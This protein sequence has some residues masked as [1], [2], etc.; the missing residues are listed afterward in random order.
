MTCVFIFWILSTM[1]FMFE[2]PLYFW[3]GVTIILALCF[4]KKNIFFYIIKSINT[5]KRLFSILVIAYQI[6]IL[7]STAWMIRSDAASVYRAATFLQDMSVTEAYFSRYPNNLLLLIY[8]RLF[9][10]IFGLKYAIWVMQLL[11]MVYLNFSL[12]LLYLIAKK[13]FSNKTADIV[14]FLSVFIIGFSPQ[15]MAM[16]TDI[17]LLP[18]ITIQLYLIAEI[19][20]NRFSLYNV[21]GLAFIS[22]IGIFVRPTAVILIIAA[23]GI[24]LLRKFNR[25]TAIRTIT[26]V[27]I[28]FSLFKVFDYF[29]DQQTIVKLK[30]EDSI[31]ALAYID[32]GLT[33]NGADQIDFQRGLSMFVEDGEPRF[34]NRVVLADINRRLDEYTPL[35]FAGHLFL[36]FYNTVKEGTLQWVYRSPIPGDK[37]TILNPLLPYT[38]SSLFAKI[39]RKFLIE[40]DSKYFTLYKYIQQVVWIVISVG[41]LLN[42]RYIK[43]NYFND[44]LLLTIF[45]GLLFLMIFEGGK[46]RYLIQFLPEILLVSSLGISNVV[47]YWKKSIVKTGT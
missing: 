19:T 28:M 29:K 12:F 31:T 25:T 16:Y 30:K 45:G 46:T 4:Y 38:E 7:I 13:Y 2:A 6:V 43:D 39:I 3:F 1:K 18:I 20:T 35:S 9:F 33:F 41:L 37:F 8:E 27:A 17:M 24:L 40:V 21:I 23:V 22:A 10:N 42:V 32:L 11:N 34:S 15:F 5:H 14:Y 26:L 47:N 44:I 36:K